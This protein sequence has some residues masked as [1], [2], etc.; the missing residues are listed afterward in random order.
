[1]KSSGQRC[2][3]TSKNGLLLEDQLGHEY[4]AG[5]SLAEGYITQHRESNHHHVPFSVVLPCVEREKNILSINLLTHSWPVVNHRWSTLTIVVSL[6]MFKSCRIR[7]MSAHCINPENTRSYL[8][9]RP[10]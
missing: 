3:Q 6:N 7:I 8:E 10:C 1:M 9:C 4:G 2:R 5:E